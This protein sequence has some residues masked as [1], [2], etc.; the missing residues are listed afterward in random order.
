MGLVAAWSKAGAAIGTQV[1]SAILASW[2]NE[3]KAN[4]ATFLIGS[5]FAVLGAVIAWFVIPDVGRELEEGDEGW[6]RYLDEQG[7]QADF[8]DEV[9]RDPA[10]VKMDAV[11]S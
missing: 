7:W 9:T 8:G 1:F 4:Q 6:K 3:G 2:A 11:G 5:S 10:R